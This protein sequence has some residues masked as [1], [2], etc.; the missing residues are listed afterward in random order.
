MTLKQFLFEGAAAGT[1][2]T[3]ANTGA[4]LI[5][6]GGGTST[7][8]LAAASNGAC[9]IEFVSSAAA[10]YN[11]GRF[12]ATAAND[13]IAFTGVFLYVGTGTASAPAGTSNIGGLTAGGTPTYPLFFRINASNQFVVRDSAAALGAALPTLT[14]GTQY[15]IAVV[16]DR[17]AG[18][19]TANLY[20]ATGTT[21]IATWSKSSGASLGTDP[22]S[23]IEVGNQSGNPAGTVRWDDLQLNDGATSEIGAYNPSSNPLTGSGT[24]TPT[25]GSYP[26]SV[27]V[28]LSATGGS[29]TGRQFSVDWGDGATSGPQTSGTFAHTYAAAGNYSPSGLVTEP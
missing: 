10:Q 7:F 27:T 17:A 23:G 6:K 13:K 14:P 3:A 1:S 28:T 24:L 22:F 29:G 5:N 11:V 2:A 21:P 25:S 4:S 8:T 18:S 16:A 12:A 15:R 19:A 9:G 20:T 26:L